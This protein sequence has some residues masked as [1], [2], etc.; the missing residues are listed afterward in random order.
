MVYIEIYNGNEL[1]GK[2]N[3]KKKKTT[4]KNKAA[5]DAYV[6]LVKQFV[7]EPN[8]KK[9]RLAKPPPSPSP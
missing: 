9:P 2:G 6:N 5:T 7:T 3:Y 8:K 1:I 4:T